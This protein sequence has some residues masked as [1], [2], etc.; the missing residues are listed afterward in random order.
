MANYMSEAAL[1]LAA[2]R[3]VSMTVQVRI[4]SGGP[5]NSGTANR[6]PNVSVDHPGD[7]WTDAAGGVAETNVNSVFGV[8]DAANAQTV[9][10]YGCFVGNIFLGWAD[11][12]NPI[13]VAAGESFTLNSGTVEC[14]FQRP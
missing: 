1:N 12:V 5:G 14:R 10:A 6:I 2:D 4:Y 3:I 8:L 13:T 11:L 7:E 9:M